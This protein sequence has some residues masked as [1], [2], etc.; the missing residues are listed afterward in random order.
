MWYN[1][2]FIIRQLKEKHITAGIKSYFAFV[3]L[4]KAF[5]WVPKKVI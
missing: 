2:I 4:E 3:D 5:D 1:A